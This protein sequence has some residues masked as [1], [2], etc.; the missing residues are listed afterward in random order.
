AL[1]SSK[2][3]LKLKELT[4]L[5][6]Y[7][8]NK[9]MELESE[10]IDI[11]S[12]Y[13]ERIRSLKAELTEKSFKQRRIIVDIDEDVEIYLEEAQAKLYI[14]DLEHPKKVLSMQDVDDEEP[15]E[16][17][18]VLE[19]VTVAKLITEVVTT[20][21]ATT[22]AEATKVSVPRRKRGVVI[23]DP[24]ETT[25]T[26]VVHSEV[27]SKNKGKELN[28]DIN[29]N[30]VIEKVKRNE[31][32]NDAVMKY[33]GLK[34]KP[35]TEAQERK[36]MII[37]SKNMA[38]Y[39]I[40]YFKGMTYSEIRPLFEKHYNYNQ[41]FL[42][43]VNE[44]VTVPEKEVEVKG[45][46]REG[47][48]FEKEITKK[49][50]M[51]EEAEE[52]KSHLQI[53]SNNNDDVYIEATPLASKIPIVG[54]KIHLERNK[55]YFKIIRAYGN[56]KLFLSFSTLLK[57]FDREDLESLWK[58][59]KQRIEKIEPKNY[60]DDYLLKT[61]NIMF[62]QPDVEANAKKDPFQWTY[63]P[64]H[65]NYEIDSRSDTGAAFQVEFAKFQLNFERFMAQLCCSNY[66]GLFNGGNC[67]SCSIIGSENEFVHD[68]NPLPY[69]NTP[70]FSYQSPQHN[71]A[72]LSTHTLE[73]SRRFNYICY[74]DDDDYDYEERTI[75]LNEIISQIPPSIVI[76]TYPPVLPIE[77]P[78]VSLITG[79]EELNTIPEK[80][81]N[82]FI[83]SSVE[84]LVLVLQ[85]KFVTFSNPLFNLND[86]FISSD[87]ESL[88]D[89]DVLE[90]NVDDEEIN[91][92]DC[93][94]SHYDSK[95][96]ILYLES[97]LTEDLVYYDPSIPAMSVASI[98]EGF[99][100]DPPLEENDDLFDLEFKNDDWKKILYDAPIDDLMTE[101]KVFDLEI[102]DQ[103]FSPT[104]V[105]LPFTDRHYIFFTYVV[106][107]LLLY[108]TYPVVSPFLI[109]SG[110]G[111]TILTLA[112]LLFIFLIGVEHS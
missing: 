66:G 34:T 24:K 60:T 10:V 96:D 46:K 62:E 109:S 12:T 23:Q 43:E 76:T 27:Q 91:V 54:Y 13:K 58:L 18:E 64:S 108:F 112:S 86:D 100:N 11:K 90:D 87:G 99:T 49:Q 89:E 85:E 65:H 74:D 110:S 32:L 102:H 56:H 6:T 97:L 3:S 69:Y 88:F 5:C 57:N 81:S 67:L 72:N 106:Q 80:E 77:D 51:D 9:V 105:S 14:I 52:L 35:L 59:I 36:N 93:E 7:L 33:Q 1:S 37:Y 107:I 19:V 61:L 78:K 26:V 95:G 82:E 29:W 94:D 48:S 98:L 30:A 38:G 4:D 79:S 39:K 104:Y 31:R 55:P 71:A 63:T 25:S 53:V 15:A 2:D 70:D 20:A 84:D 50:K 42:K 41:A 83:K 45:H 21:G 75:P 47:E 28:A 16:V 22:T 44:E 73:P 8:S 101:D 40:N 17:E 111:D 92:L 103:I 68:P